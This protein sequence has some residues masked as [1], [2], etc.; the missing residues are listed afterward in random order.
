MTEVAE[1][2]AWY[3]ARR[4]ALPFRETRDPYRVW[5][6]EVMLQQT[7]VRTVIPYY[8]AFVRRFPT[9]ADLAAAPVDEVLALWSGLGYYRRARQ[10]HRAAREMV[11]AGSGLAGRF[12]ATAAELEAY[13][14]IGPYTAAAVA[15]IAFG[16]VVPVLDGNV[17][18]LLSRRFATADDPKR[19]A[20]RRK[21]LAAAAALLDPDRPG[22]SNQALMELGATVCRPTKP[23]CPACVLAAGC[24]ARRRGDP[25]RY[26]ATRRRRRVERRELAVAVAREGER[27]LLFR[28]PEDSE[29][30]PGMWELPN[31][32]RGAT[33]AATAAALGRRY[34]GR[35]RLAE[36]GATVRHGIT[37]RAFE[38]HVYRA[39]FLAG[40]TV[41]EGPEAAWVGPE[42]RARFPASSMV[43][44]VL[45]TLT[46]SAG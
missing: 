31:V 34:G 44:K 10:L 35:W 24:R 17:E 19:R 6:S 45:R 27:V 15:S 13:P 22:D 36:A 16:E 37:Y 21:L 7:Q 9:V 25:E 38:I 43:E 40:D 28:R 12:P 46:S 39:R 20:P 5:I 3:D 14:G 11:A 8:Q 1:L 23:D 18:R 32:P 41:A 42:E 29:V 2:L 4:R 30:L 33:E 26:P